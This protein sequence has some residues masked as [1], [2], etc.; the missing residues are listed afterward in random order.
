MAAIRQ[1]DLPEGVTFAGPLSRA[2]LRD[3][4]RNADVFVFPSFF[5]GFGLVLLEAMACGLPA[6]ATDA[7]AGPEVLDDQSGRL[8]PAGN[9]DA[10]VSL[11]RDFSDRRDALPAMRAAARAA[12]SRCTWA[13][14]RQ[15]VTQAVTSYC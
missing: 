8:M 2:A 12:A 13:R 1:H 15:A 5:E 3:A 14:Y 6:I 9:L 4:Y 7:T 11:L 10:L